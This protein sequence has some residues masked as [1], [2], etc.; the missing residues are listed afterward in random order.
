MK[1]S[2]S[3]SSASSSFSNPRTL[4]P[5]FPYNVLCTVILPLLFSFFFLSVSSFQSVA[6]RE[7]FCGLPDGSCPLTTASF[8]GGEYIQRLN[9]LGDQVFWTYSFM[10]RLQAPDGIIFYTGQYPDY[11]AVEMVSG[12][13]I[14]RMNC[15]SGELTLSTVNSG[16]NIMDGQYHSVKV[17]GVFREG[18]LTI[19]DGAFVV[20]GTSPGTFQFMETDGKVFVGGHPNVTVP[21][22]DISQVFASDYGIRGCVAL[23]KRDSLEMSLAEHDINTAQ[24]P[25]V[26]SYCMKGDMCYADTI[27][28]IGVGYTLLAASPAAFEWSYSVEF[29]TDARNGLI[30]HTSRRHDAITIELVDGRLKAII[31]NGSGPLNLEIPIKDFSDS[32]WHSVVLSGNQRDIVFSADNTL[33]KVEG[34]TPGSHTFASNDGLLYIGGHADFLVGSLTHFNQHVNFKGCIKNLTYLGQPRN[35]VQEMVAGVEASPACGNYVPPVIYTH[36][37]CFNDDG[38]CPFDTIHFQG[39]MFMEYEGRI[40][41]ELWE[42]SVSI[43]T[44]STN[45]ILIYTAGASDHITL[46]LYQ[47]HL[48]ARMSCGTG[49]LILSS[50]T[51]GINIADLKWHTITFSGNHNQAVLTIDGAFSMNGVSPGPGDAITT[52]GKLYVGGMDVY[53]YGQTQGVSGGHTMEGCVAGTMLDGERLSDM[54]QTSDDLGV[55][56]FPCLRTFCVSDTGKCSYNAAAIPQSSGITYSNV[57]SNQTSLKLRFGFKTSQVNSLIFY[58]GN[59]H[60][61]SY[62]SVQIQDG[63]LAIKIDAGEGAVESKSPLRINDNRWHNVSVSIEGS[64]MLTEIDNR[65]Y[66]IAGIIPGSEPVINT[67]SVLHVAHHSNLSLLYTSGHVLVNESFNGCFRDLE[68]NEQPI[69]SIDGVRV[70]AEKITMCTTEELSLFAGKYE[71]VYCS[72]SNGTCPIDIIHFDPP[73]QRIYT[74]ESPLGNT[75]NVSLSVKVFEENCVLFVV[76]MSNDS[77]LWA[78]LKAGGLIVEAVDRNGDS[79]NLTSDRESWSSVNDETYHYITVGVEYDRLFAFVD[80]TGFVRGKGSEFLYFDAASTYTVR[81]GSLDKTF[82]GTSGAL[83]N[84]FAGCVHRLQIP[85]KSAPLHLFQ[86]DFSDLNRYPCSRALCSY[87]DS[88]CS[89]DTVVFP[90]RQDSFIELEQD[91]DEWLWDISFAMRTETKDGVIIYAGTYTDH[92]I[93]E[94]VDGTL[95]L[96]FDCGSGEAVLSTLL[97]AISL[98]N[99]EWHEVR[100]KIDEHHGHLYIDDGKFVIEGH[101]GGDFRKISSFGLW[102]G[103]F[104]PSMNSGLLGEKRGYAGCI[105]NFT[106]NGLGMNLALEYRREVNRLQVCDVLHPPDPDNNAEEFCLT[107]EG[108]CD[109]GTVAFNGTSGVIIENGPIDSPSYSFSLSFK[110]KQSGGVIFFSSNGTS[111]ISLE[112]TNGVIIFRHNPGTG[113]A[114]LSSAASDHF[115]DDEEWHSV[116]F[117]ANGTVASLVVDEI[118]SFSKELSGES[119]AVVTD[120]KICIGGIA[121]QSHVQS[122]GSSVS[123]AYFNGCVKD[124][125]KNGVNISLIT[126]ATKDLSKMPNYPCLPLPRSNVSMTGCCASGDMCSLD[127]TFYDGNGYNIIPRALPPVSGEAYFELAFSFKTR[128]NYGMIFYSANMDAQNYLVVQMIGGMIV[129]SIQV[130]NGEVTLHSDQSLA[131][132]DGFWHNLTLVMDQTTVT[133]FVD[134]GKVMESDLYTEGLTGL[135]IGSFI[136]VGGLKNFSETLLSEIFSP[137]GFKGCAKDITINQKYFHQLWDSDENM[138]LMKPGMES[139]EPGTPIQCYG[140]TSSCPMETASYGGDSFSRFTVHPLTT[141][142]TISLSIR[143]TSAYGTLAY[144]TDGDSDYFALLL[145]SHRLALRVGVEGAKG[146]I[147]SELLADTVTVTD[148]VWH[149]VSVGVSEGYLFMVIDGHNVQYAGSLDWNNLID[150]NRLLFIGGVSSYLHDTIENTHNSVNYAG[151]V[152]NINFN[153][154]ELSQVWH[155]DRSLDIIRPCMQP[156]VR[157]GTPVSCY[158]TG[159]YCPL[160]SV[161]FGFSGYSAFAIGDLF[162]YFRLSIDF[163]T[164]DSYGVMMYSSRGGEYFILEM[165]SNVLVMRF[166]HGTGQ[167]I[168]SSDMSGMV[169]NDGQWHSVVLEVSAKL[170]RM[171]I[172]H[173]QFVATG[174]SHGSAFGTKYD[175]DLYVG[176]VT[177]IPF[178]E[179]ETYNYQNFSGCMRNFKVGQISKE[180]KF[181]ARESVGIDLPC[182]KPLASP[183]STRLCQGGSCTV[184]STFYSGSSFMEFKRIVLG[185]FILG[186]DFATEDN[187]GLIF[188]TGFERIYA[189][190]YLFGGHLIVTVQINEKKSFIVVERNGLNATDGLFHSALVNITNSKL[191]VIIDNIFSKSV[192]WDISSHVILNNAKLY[193]GGHPSIGSVA[194]SENLNHTVG[195]NGCLKNIVVETDPINQLWDYDNAHAQAYTCLAPPRQHHPVDFGYCQDRCFLDSLRIDPEGLVHYN[196][197]VSQDQN[198]RVSMHFKTPYNEGV[199]LHVVTTGDFYFVVELVGGKMI[200]SMGNINNNELERDRIMTENMALNVSDSK[201]HSFEFFV[202]ESIIALSIDDGVTFHELKELSEIVTFAEPLEGSVWVGGV[203]SW[204]NYPNRFFHEYHFTG[205]VRNLT[206]DREKKHFFWDA[207]AMK[208]NTNLDC[209]DPPGVEVDATISCI[210]TTC[211]K[212]VTSFKGYGYLA[213]S[214]ITPGSTWK[215][216]FDVKTAAKYGIVFATFGHLTSEHLVLEMLSGVF[217]L[218]WRA[219]GADGLIHT[220]LDLPLNDRQ[221]HSF[222]IE[223]KDSSISL[224]VDNGNFSEIVHLHGA[225]QS[226]DTGSI[227]YLGGI[228]SHR[229]V[230]NL[231]P[232][233]LLNHHNFVGCLRRMKM[234]NKIFDL[235]TNPFFGI[236]NEYPC[237]PLETT[238][239]RGEQHGVYKALQRSDEDISKNISL[240]CSFTFKTKEENGILL[241]LGKHPVYVFRLLLIDSLIAAEFNVS[242]SEPLLLSPSRNGEQVAFSDDLWHNVS[243]SIQGNISFIQVDDYTWEFLVDFEGY[244][245]SIASHLNTTDTSHLFI[246]GPKIMNQEIPSFNGHMRYFKWNHQHIDLYFDTL[247]NYGLVHRCVAD[248]DSG[249]ISVDCNGEHSC[250]LNAGSFIRESFATFEVQTPDDEFKIDFKFK[251]V[252]FYGVLFYNKDEHGDDFVLFELLSGRLLMRSFSNG[253]I[254]E[255]IFV[256]QSFSDNTWHHVDFMRNTTH[257]HVSL[258]DNKFTDTLEVGP[259]HYRPDE[260]TQ[261]YLSRAAITGSGHARKK[262]DFTGCITDIKINTHNYEL[263]AK[264]LNTT[265]VEFPCVQKEKIDSLEELTISRKVL[266]DVDCS[267]G[268]SEF[269]T[270]VEAYFGG[271]Y[272]PHQFADYSAYLSFQTHSSYG[273]LFQYEYSTGH[274]LGL[275]IISDHLVF[276][277]RFG[278][279]RVSLS[280]PT[281]VTLQE[282][283]HVGLSIIGQQISVTFNG[284]T[285]YLTKEGGFTSDTDSFD[286]VL[287]YLGTSYDRQLR[288]HASESIPVDKFRGCIRNLKLSAT[289]GKKIVE[290]DSPFQ[291]PDEVLI[292]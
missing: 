256:Q 106:Y 113:E 247:E 195:F 102:V 200:A 163:K 283:H 88:S 129:A 270:T 14:M 53:V 172:D 37:I 84:H 48:Q 3:R 169:L 214:S 162:N 8:E 139:P 128:A 10:V 22:S 62:F 165:V 269:P 73:T 100:M 122:S 101:S 194:G 264:K 52:N 112:L 130:G 59:N 33:Y 212:D 111:Y 74:T 83:P 150:T 271:V 96:R 17:E 91:V 25:C 97:S 78:G 250:P 267:S 234:N 72:F 11:I 7:T 61:T 44:E 155:S 287:F 6:A 66:V 201:W 226:L 41:Y 161:Q 39:N 244:N 24:F 261:V 18:T 160:S 118:F 253:N 280:H 34:E 279:Q 156:L 230:D 13:L 71:N 189:M 249:E 240:A 93:L 23:F 211:D 257:I 277:G 245:T 126:Q 188:Y 136:Q 120:R 187:Y 288:L 19:D 242:G 58:S 114:I 124:L 208:R 235:V 104:I 81:L 16:V 5:N 90:G 108:R 138:G 166:D 199:L 182:A 27:S 42:F 1:T 98:D 146:T 286:S 167:G 276:Y 12:I 28:V 170:G 178:G 205:C 70:A 171:D 132:A 107:K 175:S 46:E 51:S 248:P 147:D 30:L 133:L 82:T 63:Y 219:G 148:G 198:F 109:Y 26:E 292:M 55:I 291:D 110:A 193:F 79:F 86:K 153:G 259:M 285:L 152:R 142:F 64:D 228:L 36:H 67:N 223:G 173:G 266:T 262:V 232:N 229:E 224:T 254:A 76:E 241:G 117:A 45:G 202:N 221:W 185:T 135:S 151:C 2:I 284:N 80:N 75:W 103:G 206:V 236:G 87:Q 263:F 158:D 157:S 289:F 89:N 225:D 204:E 149:E 238:T 116:V 140:S 85:D 164:T 145:V 35:L 233:S 131:L 246:G 290:Y 217:V 77:F 68:Q 251:T 154:A 272:V 215:V 196:I 92:L 134:E 144:M 174:N 184:E 183:R 121:N 216:E 29:K 186:F 47:G 141:D 123:T 168:V 210:D 177:T 137:I 69:A 125:N 127:V 50:E 190:G 197:D 56:A 278:G 209:I 268:T 179:M 191:E 54:K 237:C 213:S 274:Y 220:D 192:T 95:E 94:L 57:P 265:A 65:L 260:F 159:E 40:N 38:T 281:L 180:L 231:P 119:Q 32:H 275:A 20:K 243:F 273:V 176:G 282:W 43:K 239:L 60:E 4:F 227:W 207:P 115:F 31:D 181:D 203:D 143:T 99:G 49:E 218:H 222:V 15:G 105:K 21:E 252:Y 255:M 9:I 258:D